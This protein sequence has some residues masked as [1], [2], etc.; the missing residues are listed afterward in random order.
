MAS[1]ASL[2]GTAIE[3]YMF[4]GLLV[5]VNMIV[6]IASGH[7]IVQALVMGLFYGLGIAMILL[8]LAV[9]WETFRGGDVSE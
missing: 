9:A 4:G 3:W 5:V 2:P 1:S 8:L 7:A 6:L